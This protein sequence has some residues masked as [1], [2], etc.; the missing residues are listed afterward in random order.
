MTE[1]STWAE[2]L[3]N[4]CEE[5][6]IKGKGPLCVVLTLTRMRITADAPLIPEELVTEQRGQVKG[7]GGGA[8]KAIL[9][10][11]G[12]TRMLSSEGGRTSRGSMN[13]MLEY[14]P[15]LN[16]LAAEGVDLREVEGWWIV[17]VREY[18]DS[19][20]FK[21]NVD[22]SKSLISAIESL[23]AQAEKKQ[24]ENR[25]TM[26]VGALLQHLVGAKLELALPRAEVKHNSFSTADAP[27]TRSGDFLLGD[28]VIHVTTTPTEKLM[29]KCR[30]N[31]EQ[32]LRPIIVTRQKGV[33]SAENLAE[34]LGLAERIDIYD[35]NQ[36]LSLN[37]YE[38]F[39]FK[40]GEQADTIQRFVD[41]Y[42][43]IVDECETDPSLRIEI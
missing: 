36:F 2:K 33:T 4:F 11:Y 42:N 31:L 35:V 6:R 5:K 17:K 15:F 34:G 39:M 30:G 32:G 24:K 23:V 22:K 28:S 27:T 3:R 9:E 38:L 14:V 43:R 13:V 18:F 1:F 19:Q 41:T 25:G 20:P 21:L 10:D 40:S 29:E 8:I 16:E 7:L 37:L 12:I 26:Y